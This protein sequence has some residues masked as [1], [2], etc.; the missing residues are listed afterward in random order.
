[1]KLKV[2]SS[3]D[4]GYRSAS[5]PTRPLVRVSAE[6]QLWLLGTWIQKAARLI[7]QPIG[8]G[9]QKHHGVIWK[10]VAKVG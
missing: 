6:R 1:M 9:L 4:G 5:Q 7:G 10:G 2:M 8:T 3:W